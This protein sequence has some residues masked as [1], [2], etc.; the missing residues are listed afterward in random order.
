[1]LERLIKWFSFSVG[2][3][4]LPMILSIVFRLTFKMDVNFVDYTSELIFMAVT[5]SATSIGDIV[6]LI[7]KGV[8]GIHITIMLIFLIFISL[9]CISIYEMQTLGS[10]L[11]IPY[12]TKYINIFTIVGCLVSLI[13]GIACQVFLERIEG[14][15]P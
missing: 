6:S 7:Q 13:I 15:I 5:L 4:V 14:N 2:L 8:T 3:I 10:E 9:I 11:S 12:D 1:M